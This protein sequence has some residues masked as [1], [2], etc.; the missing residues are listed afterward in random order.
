V[1]DATAASLTGSFVMKAG[2]LLL[3]EKEH[4]G[5]LEARLRRAGLYGAGALPAFL[6]ARLL[7]GTLLP[8]AGFLTLYALGELSPLRMFLA[9]VGLACVGSLAPGL[10]LD[11]RQ[12]QYQSALRRGLPDA[13]DLLVLCLEGG[14]SLP[15]AFQRVTEDLELVHPTLTAELNIA[16]REMQMGLSAGEAVKRLG[17]RCGLDDLRDLAAVLLQSERYG[18]G[19]AKALRIHADVYRQDR[20]QRAEEMAQKAAVKI[21]FPTLLCIFPA[22]F[23][24]LLGPAAYQMANVLSKTR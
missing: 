13:L 7:L 8:A 21:L 2:E 17:E 19:V 16:L 14:G 9:G 15:S 23:I 6:G 22:I 3:P 11:R 18:A 24:V 12:R 10:W 4:R 5:P 1:D 20:Q